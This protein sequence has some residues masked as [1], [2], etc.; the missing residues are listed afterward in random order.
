MDLL[1]DIKVRLLE[2]EGHAEDALIEVDGVL[3]VGADEG[4]VVDAGGGDLHVVSS[5]TW[6]AVSRCAWRIS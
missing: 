3:T 2:D 1:G 5:A 6:A 4:D